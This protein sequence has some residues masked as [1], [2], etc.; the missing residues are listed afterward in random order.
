[1]DGLDLEALNIYWAQ[2]LG[3]GVRPFAEGG[4]PV[5]AVSGGKDYFITHALSD[6]GGDIVCVGESAD[7]CQMALADRHFVPRYVESLDAACLVVEE[8]QKRGF[9]LKLTSPFMPDQ[10][11]PNPRYHDMWKKTHDHWGAS[12]DFQGTTDS[13]PPWQ[14]SAVNPAEAICYAARLCWEANRNLDNG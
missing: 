10:P 12:F 13:N 14:A 1:M 6:P 8:M 5:Q 4:E 9:W 2:E 11:P 7:E 3:W